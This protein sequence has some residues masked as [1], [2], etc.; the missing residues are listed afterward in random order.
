MG[1]GD[2]FHVENTNHVGEGDV[3]QQYGA[4]SVGKQV[5][6]GPGDNVVS[7]TSPAGPEALRTVTVQD[8]DYV[9]GDKSGVQIGDVHHDLR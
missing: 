3:I 2:R 7:K 8:G 9:S 5:H 1:A 4:G 6:T